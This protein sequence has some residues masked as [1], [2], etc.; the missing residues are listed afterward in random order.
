MSSNIVRAERVTFNLTPDP[1]HRIVFFRFP[2][3]EKRVGL[4]GVASA[5]GL[6][7][8]YFTRLQ[9][10]TPDQLK[11]LQGMGF[12]GYSREALVERESW[13]AKARPNQKLSAWTISGP[14]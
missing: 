1:K 10:A 5:C 8:N 2:D 13:A 11:A 12:E 7:K 6:N 4:S 3:G 9:S 14:S